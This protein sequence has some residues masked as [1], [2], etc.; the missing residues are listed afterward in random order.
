[1]Y[2]YNV[3]YLNAGSQFATDG[4][5]I[6]ASANCSTPPTTGTIWEFKETF[7]AVNIFSA[8]RWLNSVVPF[9]RLADNFSFSSR[10][11]NYLTNFMMINNKTVS[12]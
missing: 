4:G 6:L 10:S 1:L 2:V 11:K 5:V 12:Q 7:D 9:Y 3:P 8:T